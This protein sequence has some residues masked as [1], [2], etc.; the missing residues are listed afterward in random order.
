MFFT[1]RMVWGMTTSGS[2]VSWTP[3]SVSPA[4]PKTPKNRGIHPVEPVVPTLSAPTPTSEPLKNPKNRAIDPVSRTQTPDP[5]ANANLPASK[6]PD[7]QSVLLPQLPCNFAR[8]GGFKRI[9]IVGSP[10][11]SFP[12]I[13]NH[14]ASYRS[15]L[16]RSATQRLAAV[17]FVPCGPPVTIPGDANRR[18]RSSQP[19]ITF[20]FQNAFYRNNFSNIAILPPLGE[21]NPSGHI[22]PAAGVRNHGEGYQH[23]GGSG[24]AEPECTRPPARPCCRCSPISTAI[25]I[26]WGRIPSACPPPTH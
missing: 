12:R 9:T 16:E 15:A 3:K 17:A 22:G 10:V 25:T 5:R 2:P 11:S 20:L 14:F 1:T 26:R 19:Q 13:F 24:D 6:S 8:M 18:R 23:K 21:C 4:P 7:S